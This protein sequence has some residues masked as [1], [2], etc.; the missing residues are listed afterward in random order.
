MR[1]TII[2]RKPFLP[3]RRRTD[4][5]LFTVCFLFLLFSAFIVSPLRSGSESQVPGEV[6][7]SDEQRPVETCTNEDKGARTALYGGE[8][9]LIAG[10]SDLSVEKMTTRR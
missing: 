3:H 6:T 4:M 8:P 2:T 7:T 5:V 9:F 10:R 1:D